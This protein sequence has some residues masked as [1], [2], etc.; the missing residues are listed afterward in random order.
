[1]RP[2]A[3]KPNSP[4]PIDSTPHAP[5]SAPTSGSVAALTPAP[6]PTS[7]APPATSPSLHSPH[8]YPTCKLHPTTPPNTS[9]NTSST[10][11]NDWTSHG[12]EPRRPRPPKKTWV[13][14]STACSSAP[15]PS[16]PA[17]R[18]SSFSAPNYPARAGTSPAPR[19]PHSALPPGRRPLPLGR[20]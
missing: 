2:T 20:V 8:A 18:P 13:G 5:T 6:E 7:R 15:A 14:V 10:A 11:Y 12:P 4:N 19:H 9:R 16:R 17:A 3:T 1:P